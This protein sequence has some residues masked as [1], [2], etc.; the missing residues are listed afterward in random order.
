MIAL[1]NLPDERESFSPRSGAF[2]TA[3][4]ALDTALFLSNEAGRR[5]A[6]CFVVTVPFSR[7]IGGREYFHVYVVT[8]RHC[9]TTK[10]GDLHKL[11]AQCSWMG[12]VGIQSAELDP[13]DWSTTKYDE[14][15]Q[16]DD[17]VDEAWI[18]IAVQRLNSGLYSDEV[19]GRSIRAIR[20]DQFLEFRRNIYSDVAPIGLPTLTVGLLQFAPGDP[21]RLEPMA[22]FGRLAMVPVGTIDGSWGRMAAYLVESSASRGMSGA[23]VFA[24]LD[25]GEY[26]LLGVHVGHFKE[27]QEAHDAKQN[28][29]GQVLPEQTGQ[30][31][32][33]QSIGMHSQV[34]LVAPAY[35]ILQI[36]S[37]QH[38]LDSQEQVELSVRRNGWRLLDS[39]YRQQA[40]VCRPEVQYDNLQ[41]YE[42]SHPH[43]EHFLI[44][45][46]TN[47][48]W[49]SERQSDEGF[50]PW[51]EVEVEVLGTLDAV[52]DTLRSSIGLA[53]PLQS[54][55]DGI[56]LTMRD[57]G[58][59]VA[60]YL[61][62]SKNVEAIEV[63]LRV[64]GEKGSVYDL[65]RELK[66]IV[67][68]VRR[69]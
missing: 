4:S 13:S 16:D 68:D 29:E 61:N 47:E 11:T 53:S 67:Q 65:A 64:V 69:F 43:D 23:P 24:Q 31:A 20:A 25:N 9:A 63:S 54:S 48:Q 7:P 21:M 50:E 37:T 8:A 12:D 28:P 30:Q 6:T 55:S 41:E 32:N 22:H 57:E 17:W 1:T 33:A 42:S 49:Q 35:K 66:G 36:L 3:S 26:R 14:L 27:R 5:V 19:V 18:D 40:G 56:L 60:L 51:S 39:S 62:D 46:P 38:V 15:C 45:R 59:D 34:G 58:Y 2:Y 52:L 44:L 10:D